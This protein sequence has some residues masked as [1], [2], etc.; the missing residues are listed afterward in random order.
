MLHLLAAVVAVLTALFIGLFG[1]I[2]QSSVLALLGIGA[3]IWVVTL[4]V[5][6]LDARCSSSVGPVT[7]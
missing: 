4:G 5:L 3:A 7:G 2:A 1:L 6:A